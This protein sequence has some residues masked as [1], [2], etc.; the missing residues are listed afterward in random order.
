MLA[1]PDGQFVR[2]LQRLRAA[3]PGFGV[4]ARRVERA[5][6]RQSELASQLRSLGTPS[7]RD[8]LNAPNASERALVRRA[9]LHDRAKIEGL[10][11]RRMQLSAD[12]MLAVRGLDDDA[13]V[14]LHRRLLQV[15]VWE[16]DPQRSIE[17][18][19]DGRVT[20]A[21]AR[22]REGTQSAPRP[23]TAVTSPPRP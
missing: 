17:R 10:V 4:P 3:H 8:R 22:G 16:T 13:F 1:L 14:A 20:G 12:V 18:W 19:L 21:Q 2:A 7:T 6:R 9:I 15:L 11:E 5:R 23:L